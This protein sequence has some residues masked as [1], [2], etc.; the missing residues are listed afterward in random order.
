MTHLRRYLEAQL[1]PLTLGLS[2]G[3]V[4]ALVLASAAVLGGK[5]GVSFD[6]AFR[7]AAVAFVT[8][9]VTFFIAEYAHLRGELVTCY[10]VG[11]RLSYSG[12]AAH[13]IS[14]SAGQET[15]FDGHAHALRGPRGVPV[16]KGRYGNLKAAVAQLI[17]FSWSRVEADRWCAPSGGTPMRG[18]VG[19]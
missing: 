8:G 4:N 1:R 12:R 10:L 9:V 14:A 16:G 2:D 11:F 18:R 17:G 5:G 15:F 7:V 13:R 19:R 6:L 3:I